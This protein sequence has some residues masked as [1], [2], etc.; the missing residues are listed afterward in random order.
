MKLASCT[1]SETG[2][3]G[4]VLS[5][6][7]LI[8]FVNNTDSVLSSA[9]FN[10][11]SLKVIGMTVGG[12]SEQITVGEDG[13]VTVSFPKELLPDDICEIFLS[14]SGIFSGEAIELPFLADGEEYE[15]NASIESDA[16]LDLADIVHTEETEGDLRVYSIVGITV[17]KPVLTVSAQ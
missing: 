13:S 1:D 10:V 8:E 3:G 14:F 6:F 15:L 2:E 5:G 9:Q 7:C 4:R 17:I 12:F 11:G 16:E